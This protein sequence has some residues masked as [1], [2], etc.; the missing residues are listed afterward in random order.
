MK[1]KNHYKPNNKKT[2]SNI[3]FEDDI[4]DIDDLDDNNNF[5]IK[6]KN[7]DFDTNFD[8]DLEEDLNF[9]S[10]HD[11][12]FAPADK[13]SDLFRK[14]TNFEPFLKLM[15]SEWLGM[16]WDES[17][18][19][20]IKDPQLEPI[21]NYKG[22]RWCVNFLRVY[23]RDNNIITNLKEDSYKWMMSDV[24]DVAVLNIGTRMEEFG[25]KNLA[26]AITIWNQ[27]IHSIDLVLMGAGGNRN[28]ADLLGGSV[29]LNETVVNNDNKTQSNQNKNNFLG[30]ARQM[31]GF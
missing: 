22:A 10:S 21:M 31:L 2:H 8:K 19:K 18:Q 29:K 20:M 3:D 4:E 28:Y 15:I 30:K 14:L 11:N 9:D 27:L 17:E 12:S 24:I 5:D 7:D 16:V 26:S 23:T 6:S 25:I 1:L 13:H